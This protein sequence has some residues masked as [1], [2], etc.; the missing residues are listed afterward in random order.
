VAKPPKGLR[1]AGRLALQQL[2]LRVT[3]SWASAARLVMRLAST[4][5]RISQR[6]GCC[7]AW[8]ICAAAGQQIGFALGGAAGFQGVVEELISGLLHAGRSFQKKLALPPK[9]GAVAAVDAA[10]VP[11]TAADQAS[12]RLRRL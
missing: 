10:A 7:W 1:A 3:G 2:V 12:Q 6:R 4:P 11:G 9:A 5:A 8:A